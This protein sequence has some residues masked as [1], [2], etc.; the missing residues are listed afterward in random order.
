MSR[1]L[2]LMRKELLELRQDPRLF[3]IVI[4]APIIQLTLLGYAATP[5]VKEVPVLVVDADRSTASR[6]LIDRFDAS[7]NFR[8]VGM[9]GSTSEID[10]WLERGDAWM[11][12]SIP[13]G[14]GD[15]LASGRS[16]TLQVVAD[17]TDSNS[18]TVAMSYTRQLI[19]G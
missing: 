8:I 4:L 1:V 9:A 10:P 2:H 14:Y 7:D 3:G 16:A 5:D 12:L 18:T 11:A 15:R 13:P 6:R 17:G 19:G